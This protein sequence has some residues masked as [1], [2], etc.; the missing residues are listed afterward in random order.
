MQQEGHG[1]G[2]ND[3]P[4]ALTLLKAQ[5][6]LPLLFIIKTVADEMKHMDRIT[7]QPFAQGIEGWGGKALQPD[8][9]SP[10]K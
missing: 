7:E 1:F 2:R 5:L 6:S 8:L 9:A 3:V 10:Y 4:A